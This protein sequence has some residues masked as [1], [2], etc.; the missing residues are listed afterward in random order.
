MKGALLLATANR[1]FSFVFG[2]DLRRRSFRSCCTRG[3]QGHHAAL[4]HAP[5]DVCAELGTVVLT[6]LAPCVLMAACR[7]W[8][9]E[10]AARVVAVAADR[11]KPTGRS[12]SWGLGPWGWAWLLAIVPQLLD[13]TKIGVG[14]GPTWNGTGS[15]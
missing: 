10:L 3:E 2:W 5:A 11:D 13:S 15:E 6:G 12:S 9:T 1:L 8:S 4:D 7:M 14:R